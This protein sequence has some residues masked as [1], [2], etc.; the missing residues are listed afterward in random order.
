M[1]RLYSFVRRV[2]NSALVHGSLLV[3]WVLLI[4]PTLLWWRESVTWIVF[5]SLYAI[6][7][8]HAG[9]I[10]AALAKAQAES[11]STRDHKK[12]EAP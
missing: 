8:S 12:G 11:E 2:N 4:I 6:I 10:E 1:N 7:V 5:M 3:V 9:A